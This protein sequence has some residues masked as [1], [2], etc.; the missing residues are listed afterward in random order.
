MEPMDILVFGKETAGLPDVFHERYPDS[1]YTI[2]MFN[3]NVR[4]LNLANAV[5][6]VVYQ[7]L[8]KRKKL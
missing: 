1:F 3:P 2:P 4:S 5:G 7:Q 6:I 8:S